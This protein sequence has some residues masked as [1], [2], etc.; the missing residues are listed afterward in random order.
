MTKEEFINFISEKYNVVADY[1]FDDIN[2]PVFRH[3]DNRK[4]FAIIMTVKKRKLGINS[5]EYVNIVNLKCAQEI[6]DSMLIE[7]GIFPAYHMSKKHWISV[8]L[9][10]TVNSDTVRWLTSVSYDL[11]SK[12]HKTEKA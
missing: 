7:N 11:T 5:D 1:P 12:K 6:I 3:Q 8:M 9:N 10:D 2:T 4:W